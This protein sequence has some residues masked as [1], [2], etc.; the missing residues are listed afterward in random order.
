MPDTASTATLVEKQTLHRAFQGITLF[1]LFAAVLSL[2]SGL[3]PIAYFTRKAL[4]LYGLS[5]AWNTALWLVLR[6]RIRP[7][8]FSLWLPAL[9]LPVNFALSVTGLFLAEGSP[10]LF[11]TIFLLLSIIYLSI[12]SLFTRS[13]ALQIVASVGLMVTAGVIFGFHSP[14]P[15]VLKE[16]ILVVILTGIGLTTVVLLIHNRL[17]TRLLV[18]SRQDAERLRAKAYFDATTGLPNALHLEKDLAELDQV[19]PGGATILTGMRIHGLDELQ[20]TIGFERTSS[21]LSVMTRNVAHFLDD[22]ARS[23]D[24]PLLDPRDR[25]LYRLDGNV[26][27]ALVR[28]RT[29][30]ARARHPRPM[31]PVEKFLREEFRRLDPAGRLTF[32]GG[33]TGTPNDAP[34]RKQLLSNLTHLLHRSRTE[35]IGRM[36][37]FDPSRYH[38]FQQRER[39]RDSILPALR[40]RQFRA[41]YQPKVEI[42]TGRV[43]G[44]EALGR[45]NHPELGAISPVE[46]IPLVEE[47]GAMDEFTWSMLADTFRFLRDLRRAGRD[48][49]VSLNLSPLLLAGDWLE[50]RHEE[51]TRSGFGH[52]IEFEITE[53]TLMNLVP[54]VKRSVKRLREDGVAFAI[55]DFGTGYSNLG[56]LQAFDA[57]VLKIDKS[58][59]DG[60]PEDEANTRLVPAMI[61]MARSFGMQTVA[62]GVEVVAQRDFLARHRCDLIQG[63]FFSKPLDPAAA[64][65]YLADM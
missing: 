58:F 56:Y 61:Q 43:A 16:S 31:G 18:Q 27:V 13:M 37:P 30:Q 42:A 7:A 2:L 59:M 1:L 49:R 8:T 11:Q 35:H 63:Y 48:C 52:Q 5:A 32:Q 41:V 17:T 45:W 54:E 9:S 21:L 4:F 65:A 15:F 64:L 38:E 26:F 57:D 6:Y 62:E 36:A 51:I 47:S 10:I 44:F 24:L 55:D 46:F 60:L 14:G 40:H 20:D 28:G 23:G 29:A 39:L 19:D 12:L 25:R 50:R 53:G 34:N 22:P 33:V 3:L